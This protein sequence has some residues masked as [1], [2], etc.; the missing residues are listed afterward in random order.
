MALTNE[1]L[2]AIA[3]LM[4]SKL[5]P[6][7]D[8]IQSIKTDVTGIKLVLENEICVNIQRVAESLDLSEI[9]RKL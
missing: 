2:Q 9:Y 5:K 6:L 4:D 8:D 1:D 3:Q 7:S